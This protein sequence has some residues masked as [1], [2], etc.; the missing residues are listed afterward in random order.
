MKSLEKLAQ[1]PNEVGQWV[2]P[3][4]LGLWEVDEKFKSSST[5]PISP[6]L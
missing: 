6:I 1:V 2:N 5:L 4:K 3:L